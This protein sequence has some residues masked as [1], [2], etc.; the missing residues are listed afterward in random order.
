MKYLVRVLK[1]FIWFT[2]ILAITLFI[3]S[4]LGL[5]ESTPEAMFKEGTKSIWQI[6]LIFLVVSFLYPIT[7]FRKMDAVIPGEYSEIKDNV[8]RFMES[9][10]YRLES[11]EGETMKFRLRSKVSAFFKMF[12]D[13]ITMVKEPGGFSVEGMRREIVRIISGLEH[14]FKNES[15]DNYSKS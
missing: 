12:E 11:E 7:G 10:G 3:M 8:V 4:A 15:D 9:R 2:V 5:V 1:Y 6:A 13:R 14:K